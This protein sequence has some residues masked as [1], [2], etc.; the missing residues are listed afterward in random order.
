MGMFSKKALAIPLIA[1]LL[2]LSACSKKTED[3]PAPDSAPAASKP[4]FKPGEMVLIPAGE[5]IFGAN[6][7]DA[8]G[9]GPEQK[10]TLPAYWID[11]YEVTNGEYLDFSIKGGYASEGK[12]WRIFFTPQKV[13][14]PVVNITW[15]DCLEYC[16]WA[17]KRLPTE[18]EWEKAARGTEGRRYPWGDKWEGG[19]S[20]TFEAGLRAPAEVNQ[21]DDVSPYG[22][23]DLLGNV[24]EWTGSWY[25]PYKGNK[26]PNPDFGERYR[27]LRGLSSAFY[28]SKGHVW[29][30]AAYLPKALYGYGCRCAKDATAEEAAKAGKPG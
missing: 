16:K 29:N 14:F 26:K 28:G 19:R 2:G 18:E 4:A 7:K 20:N 22:V 23:H 8:P 9:A 21:F 27:V 5:F 12:D 17:G 30:R 13:N 24:Q 15:N 25:K 6:D 10:I 3:A 1:T 11:K